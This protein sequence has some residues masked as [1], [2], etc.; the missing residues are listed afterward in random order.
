MTRLSWMDSD[1]GDYRCAGIIVSLLLVA[2]SI[3]SNTNE[4]QASQ[5]NA[6]YDESRHIEMAVAADPEWVDIVIR[7]SRQSS[8]LSE[9]EL[10]RYDAH[11][12]SIIDIWDQLNSRAADGLMDKNEFEGWNTYFADW[13]KRYVKDSDWQRLK[14]RYNES[15]KTRVDAAIQKKTSVLTSDCHVRNRSTAEIIGQETRPAARGH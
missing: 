10:W 6:V 11:V 7:R 9:N 12:V 14:W 1:C 13:T 8:H 4:V 5:I 15:M 2:I 3:G